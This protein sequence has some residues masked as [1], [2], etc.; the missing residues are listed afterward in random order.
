MYQQGI[1]KFATL[2]MLEENNILLCRTSLIGC[3]MFMGGQVDE[4]ID[5]VL[6]RE[7]NPSLL[8]F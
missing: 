8:R 3:G 2:R 5:L 1:S 6:Y 7:S 4:K